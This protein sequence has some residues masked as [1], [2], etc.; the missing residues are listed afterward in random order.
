MY[1]IGASNM[2]SNNVEVVDKCNDVKTL[3]RNSPYKEN[4]VNKKRKKTHKADS[5]EILETS[6]HSTE[7]KDLKS[8]QSNIFL[9]LCSI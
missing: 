1:Y 4:G 7:T 3:K 2:D 8:M 9:L 5:L 6:E